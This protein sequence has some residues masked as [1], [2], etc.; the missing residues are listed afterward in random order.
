MEAIEARV[1]TGLNHVSQAHA[2]IVVPVTHLRNVKHTEKNAFTAISKVTSHN[3]VIP[4]NVVSLLES[5]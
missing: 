1:I 3:F 2:A 5:V 4:S